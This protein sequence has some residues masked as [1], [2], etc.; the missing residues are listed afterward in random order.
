MKKDKQSKKKVNSKKSKS[1][2]D[3]QQKEWM[4]TLEEQDKEWRQT[5]FQ[6]EIKRIEKSNNFLNSFIN[7]DL[8][9]F[10]EPEEDISIPEEISYPFKRLAG[11]P[12]PF[13]SSS[14]FNMVRQ[15]LFW[16]IIHRVYQCSLACVVD[17]YLRFGTKEE[18]KESIRSLKSE[19]EK[20]KTLLTGLVSIGATKKHEAQFLRICRADPLIL[21]KIIDEF[22]RPKIRKYLLP[23]YK[24]RPWKKKEDIKR[25]WETEY[26]TPFP[27]KIYIDDRS[28]TTI[29]LSFLAYK[30]FCSYTKLKSIYH[31]TKK[32]INQ[33]KQPA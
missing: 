10:H 3:E 19:I 4:Q 26:K 25:C 21:I 24:G 15:A 9:Y 16:D 2:I 7:S 22:F 12:N 18:I 1:T 6:K 20:I 23:P 8:I 13:P 28:E 29:A 11:S 27:K 33:T 5:L 32:A 31:K 17:P 14:T 30:S